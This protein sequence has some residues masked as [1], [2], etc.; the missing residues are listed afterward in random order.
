[1][2]LKPLSLLVSKSREDRLSSDETLSGR[3]LNGGLG[4]ATIG[5]G[6]KRDGGD[7]LPESAALFRVD[8]LSF[9]LV[10]T[11]DL[12]VKLEGSAGGEKEK[13]GDFASVFTYD[14]SGVRS[15]SLP[16]DKRDL[17]LLGGSGVGGRKRS[18]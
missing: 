11:L 6:D 4:G 10:C 9:S 7:L 12:L 16:L 15:L 1:M 8:G 2:V 13:I 17:R 5:R 3:L 18:L 14:L